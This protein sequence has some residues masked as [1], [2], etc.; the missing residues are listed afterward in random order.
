MLEQQRK[1][2]SKGIATEFVGEAQAD[3]AVISQVLQGNLQLLYISPEN[4]LNNPRFR[5]ML[6]KSKYKEH[7]VALVV[8]EAHCVKTW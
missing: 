7:L 4:L 6:L 1:Y 5:S 2:S 8:D 3:P